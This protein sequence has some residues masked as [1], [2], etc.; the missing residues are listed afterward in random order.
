L[1]LFGISKQQTIHECKLLIYIEKQESELPFYPLEKSGD[2][3]A[4]IVNIGY[5]RDGIGAK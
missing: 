1:S 3:E 2:I 5:N 4:R